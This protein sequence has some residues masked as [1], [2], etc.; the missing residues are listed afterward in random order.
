MNTLS[1]WDAGC[2]ILS[3]IEKNEAETGER[4]SRF[5]I[6]WRVKAQNESETLNPGDTRAF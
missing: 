2:F 1:G 6:G 5:Q 4:V 3:A